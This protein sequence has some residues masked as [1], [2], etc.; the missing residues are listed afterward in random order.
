MDLLLEKEA[1]RAREIASILDEVRRND[2]DNLQDITLAIT[3]LNDLSWALGELSDQ[4]GAVKNVISRAFADDLKLV[5][6]SVAFTLQDIWTILGKVPR[7]P[8]AYDYRK[9]WKEVSRYGRDMSK[10]SLR[11][12]L[13]AYNLFLFGLCK[14]LKR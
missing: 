7:N 11:M 4:I 5:Q 8:V 9:A 1:E 10:H 13:D 3:G 2:Q 6:D 14:V 12:R